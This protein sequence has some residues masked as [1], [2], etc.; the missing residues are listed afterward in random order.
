MTLRFVINRFDH[1]TEKVFEERFLGKNQ[2][3]K[4]LLVVERNTNLDLMV[5]RTH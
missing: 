1:D 2:F 5:R 4:D 3:E